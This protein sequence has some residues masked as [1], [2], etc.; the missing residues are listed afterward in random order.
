[1]FCNDG[2]L[3]VTIILLCGLMADCRD[4]VQQNEQPLPSKEKK[5]EGVFIPRNTSIR[6][7][8]AYSDLFLDSNNLETFIRDQQLN[9]TLA[10][11]FRNFYNNRNFQFA[12]FASD[13][14]TEQALAFSTLYNYS[15]DSSIHRKWLDGQLDSLQNLDSLTASA[16]NPSILRTELQMTW[17]FINYLDQRYPDEQEK[18]AAVLQ[19]VPARR[20]DPLEMAKQILSDSPSKDKTVN[21][22]YDALKSQLHRYVDI[23]STTNLKDLPR[24][25]RNFKKGVRARFIV[26]LKQRLILTGELEN[27]KDTSALF[28]DELQKAI[29]SFQANHGLEQD[30]KIRASL[31]RELNV[32]PTARVRQILMNLERMIWMPPAQDDKEKLI[33]VNIPEF[34]LHVSERSHKVFDMN[35]VVGKE[36]HS[37]VLFSGQLDRIT[38]NPFWNVPASIIEKEILPEIKENKNYLKE[39]DMEITGQRDGLPEIRQMPGEKN[40]LGKMKFLFPN[41]FSIYLHDSPH[42]DLFSTTERA[43]SHG[44]IRVADARKLASFLLEPMPEWDDKRIDGVLASN[45]EQTVRL[46]QPAS[47]LICYFTSWRGGKNLPEF[48]KDIY[49]HDDRLAKMLFTN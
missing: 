27:T 25:H 34:E 32:P 7:T 43:Y 11:Y 49:G 33:L 48:R 13:G 8:E 17:R 21:M 36:G 4:K 39:H 24:P 41:S 47:V 37:T 1:M 23:A 35:I 22:W 6:P 38:F 45:M 46:K 18:T 30:G 16:T 3:I 40:E 15:K 14:L 31:I 5:A 20:R 28:D 44:C 2:R 12:W 10:R 9:D 29:R 19:Y 26:A 42:K